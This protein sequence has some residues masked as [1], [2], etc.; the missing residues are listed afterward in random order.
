MRPANESDFREMLRCLEG[1]ENNDD[2]HE[3]ESWD[4]ALHRSFTVATHNVIILSMMDLLHTSR[5]DPVCGSSRRRASP[6]PHARNTVVN[7]RPSW[8]R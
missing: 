3:F 6:P 5:N 2:Y 7:I 8:R 4:I 1:G